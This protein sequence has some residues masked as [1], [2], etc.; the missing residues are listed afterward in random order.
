MACFHQATGR[1]RM[2]AQPAV[3]WTPA[4]AMRFAPQ[5][6]CGAQILALALLC[7]SAPT[8]RAQCGE[9]LLAQDFNQY[10]FGSGNYRNWSRELAEGDFPGLTEYGLGF[11]LMKVGDGTMRVDFSTGTPVKAPAQQFGLAM[12]VHNIIAG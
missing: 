9:T 7:A 12:R 11:D 4:P 6:R 2:H 5:C 8:A 1:Q 10:Q 3:R